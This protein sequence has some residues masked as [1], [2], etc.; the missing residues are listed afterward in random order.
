MKLLRNLERKKRNSQFGKRE[1]TFIPNSDPKKLE[2]LMNQPDVSSS[3]QKPKG[4]ETLA[5]TPACTTS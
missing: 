4:S 3:S 5:C 1:V 2:N